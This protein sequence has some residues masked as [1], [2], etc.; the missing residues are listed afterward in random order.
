[1]SA[2]GRLPRALSALGRT[3]S[4][5]LSRSITTT[6]V[7]HRRVPHERV[8][9][10]TGA[11]RGIGRA[12]ALRLAQDG[13]HITASDLPALQPQLDTLVSEINNTNNDASTPVPVRAHALPADVTSPEQVA[14]LV[15]GSTDTLGPLDTMV[16][17]AGIAQ[18]K[19]LLDLTPEDFRRMLDVNVAGVHHCFQAAAKQII[20]QSGG[21]SGTET[22]SGGDSPIRGRLIAAA[23]IVAFKPFALLG[24]YSAS[25]WAVRGLS[26]VYAMELAKHRITVNAY[27]P[28]IVD[29]AMWELIDQGLGEKATAESEGRRQVAKGEMIKKY[30]DELIALGRTS[31]SED[32]AKLVSFLASPDADY[33]TGQTMVVDGGIIFT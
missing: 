23:S 8:A 32:V 22:E 13:Y 31:V 20:A 4:Q 24:H 12:I 10:V 1:M 17:N 5:H 18:V 30:S 19:P 9:I 3:S 26:Q 2:L 14:A 29:T 7:A 6:P 25:K 27:A 11:A 28:G 16:A 33:V 21:Q 15:R